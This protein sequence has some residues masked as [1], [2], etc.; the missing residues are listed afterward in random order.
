MVNKMMNLIP[1]WSLVGHVSRSSQY[2]MPNRPGASLPS[3]ALAL[4]T[5]RRLPGVLYGNQAAIVLGVPDH[6][7]TILVAAKIVHPLGKPA[8]NAP[9][10]FAAAAI[11]AL[12]ENPERLNTAI[13]V[14][15]R[16]WQKKNE[17]SKRRH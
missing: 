16:Y 7:M 1:N 10:R 13:A 6:D 15:T 9:K 14:I 3:N 5:L 2:K 17:R 4:L 12:A 11:I 8:R